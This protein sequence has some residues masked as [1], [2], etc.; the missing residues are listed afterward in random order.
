MLISR[1]LPYS[2]KGTFLRSI[3][4]GSASGIKPVSSSNILN[5]SF[6]RLS[7]L[8]N[9]SIYLNIRLLLIFETKQFEDASLKRL[10]DLKFHRFI[11]FFT[12]MK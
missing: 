4:L 8:V 6:Y 1:A 2:R 3:Y 9:C 5:E 11:T 7:T 12:M 10:E